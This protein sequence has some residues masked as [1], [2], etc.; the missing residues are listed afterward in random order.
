[1]TVWTWDV[2][3]EWRNVKIRPLF[4]ILYS[5]WSL[6]SSYISWEISLI[7]ITSQAQVK[8]VQ[9]VLTHLSKTGQES[10]RD[11]IWTRCFILEHFQFG[12]SSMSTN[13]HGH[14]SHVYSAL[15]HFLDWSR[16]C[17]SHFQICGEFEPCQSYFRH[18][19]NMARY[20]CDCWI[21]LIWSQWAR[22]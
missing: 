4:I 10:E 11:G 19:P 9:Q 17:K 1:M 20:Q 21:H 13:R 5:G 15:C 3:V 12:L 14:S 8:L 6:Q 7:T 2:I 18:R 16:S 22:G